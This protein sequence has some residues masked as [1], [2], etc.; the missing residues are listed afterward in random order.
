[1]IDEA[2]GVGT[3]FPTDHVIDAKGGVFLLVTE[4][5]N[6]RTMDQCEGRV[7]RMLHKGQVQYILCPSQDEINSSYITGRRAIL[8]Q[9]RL[10]RARDLKSQLAPM[11]ENDTASELD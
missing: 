11:N 8:D 9:H 6:T 2:L 7:T 10:S 5:F 3:D 4:I 1:M